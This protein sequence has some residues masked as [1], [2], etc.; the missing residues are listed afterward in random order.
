MS[1]ARQEQ[2][3]EAGRVVGWPRRRDPPGVDWAGLAA[4]AAAPA[5]AA[6]ASAATASAAATAAGAAG[7]VLADELA[8]RRPAVFGADRRIARVDHQH[9]EGHRPARG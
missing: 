4:A 1:P 8:N 9:V 3:P 6:T 5:A 7:L 2:K